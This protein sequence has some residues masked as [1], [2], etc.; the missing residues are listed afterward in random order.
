MNR[1]S[2]TPALI[3]ARLVVEPSKRDD[4]LR[5]FREMADDVADHE[6]GALHYEYLRDERKPDVFWCY[7]IYADESARDEHLRRHAHRGPQFETILAEPAQTSFLS[8]VEL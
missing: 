5:L 7:Q 3:M 6:P 1:D 8:T 2:R 4:A